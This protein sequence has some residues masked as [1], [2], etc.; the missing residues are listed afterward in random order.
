MAAFGGTAGALTLGARA[1]Y[2]HQPPVRTTTQTHADIQEAPLQPG[3]I[4][5]AAPTAAGTFLGMSDE[6]LIERMRKAEVRSLRF[7]R[8]GSSVSFRAEFKDGSRASFKPTQTNPQSVPRKEVAAFRI[9]RWLGISLIPPATLRA[10]SQQDVLT[11]LAGDSTRG[12]MAAES[13]A[14]LVSTSCWLRARR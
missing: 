3:G 4:A 14:S 10:L 2:T 1:Y 6:I 7:N 11:K 12:R 5:P 8:G 9:S 13:P